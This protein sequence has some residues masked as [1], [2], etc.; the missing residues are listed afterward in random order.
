MQFRKTAKSRFTRLLLSTALIVAATT[1]SFASDIR[2]KLTV[3]DAV[4]RL[5]DIFT[6]TGEN[7]STIVREAPAPGKRIPLSSYE[8][9]KL[10]KENS[11]EWVRPKYLKRVYIERT[12]TPVSKDDLTSLIREEL[13][14]QGIDSDIEIRLHGQSKGK[15]IPS[16]NSIADIMLENFSLSDRKDRFS[17]MVVLPL[18]PNNHEKVRLSGSITEVRMIPVLNRV[19]SPGDIITS[20]DIDWKKYPVKRITRNTIQSSNKLIGFTVKRSMS[21]GKTITGNDI[22]APIT[23]AKNSS[24]LMRFKSGRITLTAEGRAMQNGGTGDII[25]V[26]NVKSHQQVDAVVLR[27]GLVEIQT[28]A[29]KTLASR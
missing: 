25:R 19:I 3:E 20:S 11:V 29:S 22:S 1:H 9:E 13:Y 5:S 7:G 23:I 16:D 24:V 14:A 6:D 26:I 2:E 10:A 28:L 12:G 15:Y 8:L 4:I 27:E 21:A 17:V 18:G